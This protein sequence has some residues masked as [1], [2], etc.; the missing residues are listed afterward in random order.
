M[1]AISSIIFIFV[2]ITYVWPQGDAQKSA[3]I[4]T[5]D[6]IRVS[7]DDHEF[8]VEVPS[9]YNFFYDSDGFE[10]GKDSYNYE[11]KNVYMFN[12]F[13]HGTLISFE[14]FDGDKAAFKALYDDDAYDDDGRKTSEKTIGKFKIK[15]VRNTTKDHFAVRQFIK[16]DKR[17]YVLTA[18]TRNGDSP[19]LHRFLDS[20]P[21]IVRRAEMAVAKFFFRN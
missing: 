20:L 19:E 13:Y 14:S 2:L 5:V 18:A 17:I 1:K 11:L 10:V 3:N 7:S 21:S 8:S 9:K 6:W 15:E 4:Q 12:A 16:T